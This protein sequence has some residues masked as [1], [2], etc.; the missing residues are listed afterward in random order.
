MKDNNEMIKMTPSWHND[1][2]VGIDIMIAWHSSVMKRVRLF[3]KNKY[4]DGNN[5]WPRWY[6]NGALRRATEMLPNGWY[7][8]RN[9]EREF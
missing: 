8:Y 3:L 4:S 5:N 2:C 7:L 1:E 6:I 9:G